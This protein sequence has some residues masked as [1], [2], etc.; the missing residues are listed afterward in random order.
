MAA[1]LKNGDSSDPSHVIP[2]YTGVIMWA[3]FATPSNANRS[4]W[5][6]LTQYAYIADE[7]DIDGVILQSGG[8]SV[9]KVQSF[10]QTSYNAWV[11]N[12]GVSPDPLILSEYYSNSLANNGYGANGTNGEAW[13][14]G[15]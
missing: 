4:S 2:A 7:D 11:N 13:Q 12:A 15:D 9:P 14:A 10:Y 1:L 8:Y 3:P 6:A 5:Q